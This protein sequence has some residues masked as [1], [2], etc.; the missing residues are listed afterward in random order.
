MEGVG[1]K[2]MVKFTV[3]EQ[4]NAKDVAVVNGVCTELDQEALRLIKLMK[5]WKP[6]TR[7]GKNT[8]YRHIQS[9]TFSL[10]DEPLEKQESKKVSEKTAC[11]E[12]NYF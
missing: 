6:A 7:N 1:G 8:L 2:V 11:E 4:G 12:V 10:T 5:P 9:F 3:D